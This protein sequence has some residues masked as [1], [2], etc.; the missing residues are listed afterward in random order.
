[1]LNEK[2]KKWL[3]AAGVR[4]IKTTAQAAIGGIGAATALGG[5]DWT[6]AVSTAVLAGIVSV[7]TSV[8][9]LPEVKK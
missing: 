8:A 2:N 3:K 7:L 4:A 5:V 9:G 1:M 6:L